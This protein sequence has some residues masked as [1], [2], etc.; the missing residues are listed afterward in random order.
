MLRPDRERRREERR[1]QA[2]APA[3]LL[4]ERGLAFVALAGLAGGYTVLVDGTSW[5][6]TIGLIVAAM[7]GVAGGVR[8]L[9]LPGVDVV[10][11]VGSLGVGFVLL[12]WIFAR[13]T[14]AGV[15]PTP[16]SLDRLWT[17]L[18]R[19]GVVIMEEK[20]P[21]AAGA[22]VVL[23]L[24]LAFCL[25]ALVADLLLTW[26]RGVLPFGLLLV[27]VLV[28]PAVV[29]GETPSFGTF[30]LPAAAWL[31]LLWL[32]PSP[33]GAPRRLTPDAVVPAVLVG[34][35]ALVVAA[36]LPPSLPDVTA[37]AKPWGSPPPQVF[38]RGINP[39]LQLGQNLRRNSDTVALQY[40]TSGDAPYLSVAVLRD[41][42]GKTWKPAEPRLGEPIE[43]QQTSVE[44]DVEQ[45]TTRIR[46]DALKSSMLP[47]PYP[48]VD[49]QGLDGSWT[50]Q[51]V[52]A[53]LSSRSSD[54]RNQ[55]YTVTSL[56]RQP[57]AEQM[58]AVQTEVGP[59]LEPYVQLPDD[60]PQS[61]AETAQQV[62]GGEPDEYAQALALQA[63]F[64]DGSFRY[65]EEAPVAEDYDGNGMAVVAEFLKKK[66]GYCVHFS[67]AMA[68]MA[69]SLGIP[70]RI[71]VGYAPGQVVSNDDAGRRVYQVTTDD[72]HA[73][74]QLYFSDVGWVSFEPTP[75]IGEQTR[76]DGS[77][78][79]SA[80]PTPDTTGATPT[81]TP[82]P[83]SRATQESTATPQAS[84]AAAPAP[85][86]AGLGVLA[87]GLVLLAGP[88][89]L[90]AALRRRRLRSDGSVEEWWRE[91]VA[92]ARDVGVPV[93]ETL[94]VRETA[95][96]LHERVGDAAD[97]LDRLV[98]GVERSRY[99]RP[100]A[101]GTASSDDARAVVEALLASGSRR[102]RAWP[103]SLVK[104]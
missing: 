86:R 90:R 5:W 43:T 31:A 99:A 16:S 10:A 67:S 53:L 50:W 101:H 42:T 56:D 62:A 27:A 87:G 95:G 52:G 37:V 71:V 40:T 78:D 3:V 74:P 34:V 14:L 44:I 89:L 18:D 47:V 26:R 91:V 96:V 19:A 57:T 36:V 24:A 12:T 64:Q 83:S 29:V 75:G 9:R 58:H 32:R 41:F 49:V 85:W 2:A 98:D 68:V 51:R 80:G 66:A 54:T 104:R 82:T 84:D 93:A 25:L 97:R 45:Q 63:Y 22:P 79:P 21:V 100:G 23:V 61:I 65:S 88:A 7:L 4:A 35:G 55:T 76:F 48:A 92:T 102:S 70:S 73:W 17:L 72:L 20:A 6:P 94:T 11:A 103:R 13:T 30:L 33:D 81:P 38:G 60:L 46:I 69:R 28:A 77:T 1:Q 59:S 8:A 39:M 15:V